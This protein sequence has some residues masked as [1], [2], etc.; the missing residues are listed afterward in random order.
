M[1]YTKE[2]FERLPLWARNEIAKLSADNLLFMEQLDQVKM[3]A[4][5]TFFELTSLKKAALPPYAKVD[6]VSSQ[7]AIEVGLGKEDNAVFVYAKPENFR[8]KLVII[9]LL[10]NAFK[11]EFV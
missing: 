5:N 2:Q 9:P 3:Q 6:F 11:I 10:P 4:S 7:G 8:A 1:S